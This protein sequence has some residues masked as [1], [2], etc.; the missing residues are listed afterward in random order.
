MK[1]KLQ[2]LAQITETIFAAQST[3]MQQLRT[4][5]AQLRNDLATLNAN[6]K[7]AEADFNSDLSLKATGADILWQGW[8][9]RNRAEL[10][11]RLANILVSKAEEAENLKQ[12]FGRKEVA[13]ELVQRNIQDRRKMTSRY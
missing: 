11:T 6:A 8:A 1:K 9:G 4:Q 12:A 3:T 2:E 5:E 13:A 7:Q 10:Q